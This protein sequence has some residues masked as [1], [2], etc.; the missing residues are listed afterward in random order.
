MS[1]RDERPLV[2]LGGGVIAW[3]RPSG[4][5]AFG[6]P[7]IAGRF[8][9][10]I[11]LDGEEPR[12]DAASPG[13]WVRL[14]DEIEGEAARAHDAVRRTFLRPA[15]RRRRPKVKIEARATVATPPILPSFAALAAAQVR[16]IEKQLGAAGVVVAPRDWLRLP[17]GRELLSAF[18]E[19]GWQMT[20][21]DEALPAGGRCY[22]GGSDLWLRLRAAELD[23]VLPN[24]PLANRAL[25]VADGIL[26]RIV[27]HALPP[28]TAERWWREEEPK[29]GW[30]AR[31]Q[32]LHALLAAARDG[33]KVEID[34]KSSVLF[35]FSGRPALTDFVELAK[36]R[37]VID[38]PPV[39]SPESWWRQAGEPG[40]MLAQGIPWQGRFALLKGAAADELRAVA[41]GLGAEVDE[42]DPAAMADARARATSIRT[43]LEAEKD[44]LITNR[45]AVPA[46]AGGTEAE[47]EEDG[48][49]VEADEEP[50]HA[51][52]P[53]PK[54]EG[55]PPVEEP[56]QPA[57]PPDL[58]G[59]DPHLLVVD[60]PHRPSQ[61]RVHYGDRQLTAGSLRYVKDQ[62]GAKVYR[63]EGV[64]IPR[65]A[66][67]RVE[68]DALSEQA[69]E[70]E[71]AG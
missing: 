1:A 2:V 59:Y 18:A 13:V 64:T 66:L 24:G 14:G 48:A 38:L 61:V 35:R 25:A 12:L 33:G 5:V 3:G 54:A 11:A 4:A 22:A 69:G 44:L 16:W 26:E 34:P 57:V 50:F 53:P 62:D 17:R 55:P 68:I 36:R 51:A 30:F 45:P 43:L 60:L 29:S 52:P 67:L 47:A 46:A 40:G 37:L 63:L 27:R 41:S 28:A 49:E 65:G 71:D 39:G 70:A 10:E 9:D 6:A 21:L 15:S 7:W 23:L 19:R 20:P 56:P 42:I 8:R 58:E 32:L 31:Q